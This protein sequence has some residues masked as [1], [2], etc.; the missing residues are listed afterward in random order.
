MTPL[1]ITWMVLT[2]FTKT[3]TVELS[4]QIMLDSAQAT[5]ATNAA[6]ADKAQLTDDKTTDSALYFSIFSRTVFTQEM[7]S[8]V[9]TCLLCVQKH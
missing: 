9:R 7:L 2:M 6:T 3:L 1:M 5:A 4:I 8:L